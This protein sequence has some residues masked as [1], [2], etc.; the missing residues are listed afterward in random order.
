MIR[1]PLIALA[2]VGAALAACAKTTATENP[3]A[4]AAEPALAISAASPDLAWG[5][6]PPNF[7]A[8]CEIAALHGDLAGVNADIFLRVPS[9]YKIPPHRH[10]SAE[11][12]V[13]V[14][15]ELKVTYKG[16]A[17]QTLRVGD[18]A[19]G[20]ANMP[21]DAACLSSGSCTL[22]IAFESAIDANPYEGEL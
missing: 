22:F 6:C 16:Q 3:A 19:Y 10:T 4:D 20:P 21:H 1:R 2:A 9:G 12:M 13:L 8:G 11:R 7:P 14:S 15:G 18:Y 17:A 5:P